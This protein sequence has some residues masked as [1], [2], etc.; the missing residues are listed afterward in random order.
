MRVQSS[1]VCFADGQAWAGC[2]QQSACRSPMLHTSGT[3]CAKI[4]SASAMLLGQG[5]PQPGKL[6][7]C[8]TL[9]ATLMAVEKSARKRSEHHAAMAPGWNAPHGGLRD[10]RLSAK[11]TSSTQLPQRVCCNRLCAMPVQHMRDP[12]QARG[13]LSPMKNCCDKQVSSWRHISCH[14]DKNRYYT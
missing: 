3:A 1:R 4:M 10:T 9:A 12:E 2:V 7:C 6:R 11:P 13:M 5:D 14:T 8:V